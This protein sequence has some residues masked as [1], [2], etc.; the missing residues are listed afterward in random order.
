MLSTIAI[1]ITLLVR[2]NSL[3]ETTT[4]ENNYYS[5]GWD[6][7]ISST[8]WTSHRLK[9]NETTFPRHNES[10]LRDTRIQACPATSDYT[11]SGYDRG[12]MVPASDLSFSKEALKST[13]LMTNITPQKPEFNRCCWLRLEKA[14]RG[15]VQPEQ[16]LQIVTGALF[17]A[18][19]KPRRINGKVSVPDAFYKAIYCPERKDAIG[20][21]MPNRASPLP[22]KSYLAD[23][24]T[25]E[26]LSGVTLFPEKERKLLLKTKS[27]KWLRKPQLLSINLLCYLAGILYINHT[28]N[29]HRRR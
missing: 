28:R 2:P 23:I 20:F 1:L 21:I 4:L 24:A 5:T 14:I 8:V 16:E 7:S 22:L 17:F 12:H 10:Y 9:E 18:K 11:R 15:W 26:R 6:K 3:E 27:S 13:F 19:G 25:I 29:K